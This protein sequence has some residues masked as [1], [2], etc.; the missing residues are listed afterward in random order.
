MA[1]PTTVKGLSERTGASFIDLLLPCNFC[2]RFL[3]NIEKAFFD[4]S[5]FQLV[6]RNDCVYGCCQKCIRDCA[7][8]EESFYFEKFL[9]ES[10]LEE[11]WTR[12]KVIVRCHRC[13]KSLTE[14]EKNS[15]KFEKIIRLVRGQYRGLC[16]LCRLSVEG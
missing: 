10:E 9:S 2:S 16:D 14:I 13:M 1:R 11:L 15:C 8:L 6:W 7:L 3:T 5:P 12:S 4:L